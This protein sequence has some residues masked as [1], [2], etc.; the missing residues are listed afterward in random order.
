MGEERI[1]AVGEMLRGGDCQF[2]L[3]LEVM[4]ERAL[5]ELGFLANIIDGAASIAPGSED[6]ERG[7]ENAGFGLVV[8]MHQLAHT[9]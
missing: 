5:G 4:E 3:G 6:L 7:I 2:F 1:G 8:R 9:N